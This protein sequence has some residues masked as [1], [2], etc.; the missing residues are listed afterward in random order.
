MTVGWVVGVGGGASVGRAGGELHL[1]FGVL[2]HYSVD[3]YV[4]R[5]SNE[6]RRGREWGNTDCAYDIV[7]ARGSSRW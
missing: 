3:E 5:S 2:V 1:L 4:S 6:E 7:A